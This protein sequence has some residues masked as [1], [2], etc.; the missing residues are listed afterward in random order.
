MRRMRAP[1]PKGGKRVAY[2]LIDPKSDQGRAMYERLERAR[3]HVDHEA[4][5]R[6]RVALAWCTSWKADIDGR[7]TLGKCRRSSELDREFHQYDFVILLNQAWWW[8]LATTDNQREA[9]LDHEC[10]HMAPACDE[11]TGEQKVDERNRLLWRMRKHDV[12]E[13]HGTVERHGL[14]KRDVELHYQKLRQG[15]MRGFTSCGSCDAR[16]FVTVEGGA[17][18]RCECW[19]A[20]QLRVNGSNSQVAVAS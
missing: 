4:T 12:E 2:K 13:F 6:A 9:I 19:E 8:D 11:R 14:Y 10:R 18:K 3:D 20:W 17:L 15:A 16:G 7:L 5:E 1:K